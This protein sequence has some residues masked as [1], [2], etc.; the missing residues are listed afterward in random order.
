MDKVFPKDSILPKIQKLNES[1][2]FKETFFT[3][4]LEGERIDELR[5][6]ISDSYIY[7]FIIVYI[8][9]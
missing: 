1:G 5:V 7:L 6:T 9:I 8:I 4:A 3:N 2:I